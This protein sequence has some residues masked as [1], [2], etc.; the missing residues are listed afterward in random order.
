MQK[1]MV[2]SSC[3][4]QE[5]GPRT[6][7]CS[8]ATFIGG[9]R[10]QRLQILASQGVTTAA[11]VSFHET[12]AATQLCGPMFPVVEGKHSEWHRGRPAA[13]ALRLGGNFSPLKRVLCFGTREARASSWVPINGDEWCPVLQ[14]AGRGERL[15]RWWRPMLVQSLFGA[16]AQ[17][18]TLR[19][20]VHSGE[21]NVHPVLP[22]GCTQCRHR[23]T[24][25]N[26]Q[27]SV[28]L[29]TGRQGHTL[30]N[31]GR[32]SGSVPLRKGGLS[33]R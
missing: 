31:Y 21:Q 33:C 2:Y 8:V 5:D 28:L 20:R 29:A 16:S 7:I 19:G 12:T 3:L 24:Q 14:R 4:A 10:N 17:H 6:E 22:P 15:A 32:G 27:T 11:A 13:C 30:K 9:P 18:Q 25:I 23:I 26:A 1:C